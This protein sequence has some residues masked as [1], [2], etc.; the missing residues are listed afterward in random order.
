METKVFLINTQTPH[1]STI[2]QDYVQRCVITKNDHRKC[3]ILPKAIVDLMP[4][5]KPTY[6]K[7]GSAM[8]YGVKP[9][10]LNDWL[11]E[12]GFDTIDFDSID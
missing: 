6:Y 11:V 7:V 12:N 10:S 4:V 5:R 8:V 2:L 3:L 1:Y 9:F